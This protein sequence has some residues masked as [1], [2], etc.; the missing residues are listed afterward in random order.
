MPPIAK[1]LLSR[2]EPRILFT[3]VGY[4]KILKEKADLEAERPEAVDHLKKAREMGDLS[5]NGYYKAS[6]QRLSFID[7][8]LRRV[9][10]LIKLAKIVA[11][12]NT[13][14][15]DIGSTVTLRTGDKEITYTIV[16]GYESDP[17]QHTISYQSPLGRALMGKRKGDTVEVHAPLRT[18]PYVIISIL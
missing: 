7:A 5:E 17:S 14:F 9:N 4:E 10:R 3:N 15:V 1:F 6:R 16:G 8:R 2:K 12:A 18:I 11:T 13:G